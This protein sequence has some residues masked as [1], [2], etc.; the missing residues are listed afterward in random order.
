MFVILTWRVLEKYSQED[1]ATHTNLKD[2]YTEPP[3]GASA[4]SPGTQRGSGVTALPKFIH[5][6]DGWTVCP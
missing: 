1:T 6:K 5:S 2:N 4:G 3:L